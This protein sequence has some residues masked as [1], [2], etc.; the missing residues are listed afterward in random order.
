VA[1]HEFQIVTESSDPG[2]RVTVRGDLDLATVDELRSA[3]EAAVEAG[4]PTVLVLAGCT[5]L[6]SSALKVIADASRRAREAGLG[7]A[8]A[9][10]SPQVARV[11]EISGLEDVV[12]IQTDDYL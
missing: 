11:L 8:V 2:T 3:L 9:Q 10:P 6:D 1:T 4:R 5:F 12:T 7:L